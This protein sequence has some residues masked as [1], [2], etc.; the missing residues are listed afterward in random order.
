MKKKVIFNVNTVNLP[1]WGKSEDYVSGVGRSTA[2]LL[3]AFDQNEY[4]EVEIIACK[5]GLRYC[6]GNNNFKNIKSLK[7][8]LP[9][10]YTKIY[11]KLFLN[12]YIY[13]YPNNYYAKTYDGEPY[14]LTIHDTIQYERALLNDDEKTIEFIRNNVNNSLAIVTCSIFSRKQIEEHFPSS[15]SKINVIPW[16]VDTRKFRIKPKHEVDKTLYYYGISN[17][18]FL[19]VSCK[20]PRKNIK[21]LLS[22]F[23]EYVRTG[24]D[25]ILVLIW[26]NVPDDIICEF[27]KE[28][29]CGKIL[30]LPYVTDEELIDLYN[31]SKCT[32]FPSMKE[33]FGFPILESFACGTPVLTCRN[34][35][36]EE[37][38]GELAVYGP[39]SSPNEY[40]I[41][42]H[43]VETIKNTNF[44]QMALDHVSN[45][46]WEDT[47]NKYMCL[48]S[49]V[50]SFL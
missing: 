49:N 35:S 21:M 22:A 37:V 33:G 34:S 26:G 9:E 32:V 41:L 8:L 48:Y 28:I 24:G 43:Q 13:H 14:I 38:G 19:S 6:Y 18:Y 39:E 42:L 40:A 45:F 36:L 31:G 44:S 1:L 4:H 30:F 15:S 17:N 7:I 50:C 11:R 5:E 23:R 10:R 46:T 29:E 20:D 27:S 16:G 12:N 3:E 2:C 25:Y 47:A